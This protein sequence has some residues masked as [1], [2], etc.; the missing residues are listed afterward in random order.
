MVRVPV[1]IVVMV[2]AVYMA[3]M[4]AS[5]IAAGALI[6]QT[7][8]AW[9]LF[10]WL[11]L[12]IDMHSLVAAVGQRR[13][14]ISASDLLIAAFAAAQ[15]GFVVVWAALGCEKWYLRLPITFVIAAVMLYCWY[16]VL[17]VMFRQRWTTILFI[18][19]ASIALLATVL[20]LA[21]F[22]LLKLDQTA[23]GDGL[24]HMQFGLRHV[25]VLVTALALLL[26][27]ARA[28]QMLT[29]SSFLDVFGALKLW[30]LGIACPSAMLVVLAFWAALGKGSALLRITLLTS[31]CLAIGLGM[32]S[33]SNYMLKTAV[34]RIWVFDADLWERIQFWEFRYWWIAW[35][36]MSTGLLSA[37]LLFFRTRG[38]RI[39]RT[40]RP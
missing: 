29:L 20:R 18:E 4:A 2:F 6:P 38:Y 31:G 3:E 9:A 30:R 40:S 13:E 16:Q 17:D 25:L 34:P 27:I 23:I 5:A 10:V 35:Y 21:R 19:L 14:W 26:G 33:W 11:L 12:M 36:C 32:A 24:G 37:C 28:A 8:L 7:W 22:R 15:L 39:V 1:A